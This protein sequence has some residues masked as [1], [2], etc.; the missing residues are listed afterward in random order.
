MD[1]SKSCQVVNCWLS[2]QRPDYRLCSKHYEE[3]QTVDFPITKPAP[4][5]RITSSTGGEKG[6]KDVQ[7]HAMP[8]EALQDLGRVYAFGVGKYADYNFRR[9]YDWSLSFDALLRH[10][11]AFWSGEDLDPESGLPHIAHVAWHAHTLGLFAAD[12]QYALFDDRP[13]RAS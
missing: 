9:G 6:Q 10:L 8:W 13:R 5:E 11:F 7:L 3:Y 2:S 4:E 1:R 12:P